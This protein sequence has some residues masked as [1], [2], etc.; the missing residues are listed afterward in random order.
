MSLTFG[1][2]FPVYSVIRYVVR[3]AFGGRFTFSEK[4]RNN[5][6]RAKNTHERSWC[7]LSKL[8]ILFVKIVIL[9]FSAR[10]ERYV[11]GWAVALTS[12]N[13]GKWQIS[14]H[15]GA[16]T[17]EPILTKLGK[18]DYVRDPTPHDN[19]GGGSAT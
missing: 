12:L 14:T 18:V 17:P 10:S 7:S 1:V 13:I 8:C 15:Q 11:T 16:K 19:F 5:C 3:E 6:V 9:F 2:Q 4:G